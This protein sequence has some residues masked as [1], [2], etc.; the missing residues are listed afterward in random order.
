MRNEAPGSPHLSVLS[1]TSAFHGRLFGSLSLT[2]SKAI[3]KLDI[4]AFD[5]PCVPFPALRYPLSEYAAE[6][7]EAEARA[8]Q[9][10]EETIDA[11][12]NKAPVAAVIVEPIQSGPLPSTTVPDLNTQLTQ[13]GRGR[14]QSCLGRLL[15]GAQDPDSREGHL[16]DRR[17]GPD[18]RRSV[19]P[20]FS[21]FLF[22]AQLGKMTGATG[23]FWAHEKWG[24]KHAPDFVTFRCP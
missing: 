23:A 21:S 16:H 24:L 2:R 7:A 18:R 20:L 19:A 15:Q 5:W 13:F 12:K 10:V 6:N 22:S 8:L 11:W 9:Q 4:P 3:H 14:R 17:R 1:F